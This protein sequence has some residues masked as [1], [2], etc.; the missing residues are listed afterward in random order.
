M[1]LIEWNINKRSSN[2]RSR[3]FVATRL[4]KQKADVICLVEYI[5]DVGLI[6]AMEEDYWLEESIISSGN[7][8]LIA[9]SKKYAPFGIEVVRNEEER[10]CYNLLHVRFTNISGMEL[11]IIG[12]RM[13]TGEGKCAINADKQ[14]PPLNRYLGTVK[15]PFVCVGDF[16]IR[17]FRMKH[18][19]P[20]YRVGSIRR[21]ES[22]LS[23]A[24]FIFS[25]INWCR[26]C[27]ILDHVLLS[28]KCSAEI[29]YCWDFIQ[30]DTIYPQEKQLEE[31]AA[32]R[33]RPG[34]PDHAMMICDI[35]VCE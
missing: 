23:S 10:Q 32:W 34:Y 28:P 35:D 20:E 26:R 5:H 14:T 7:Q 1:K 27:G 15:E 6:T 4:I 21:N 16:N 11:S 3:P 12:I 22:E 2:V 25:G 9:V 13:L 8:V 29:E 33:V 30:D 18:W 24:S 31:G 17:E 19:F